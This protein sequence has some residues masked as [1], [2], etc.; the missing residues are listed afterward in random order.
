LHLA[1]DE[2]HQ[3]VACELTIPES[4]DPTGVPDLLDQ[5]DTPFDTFIADGAY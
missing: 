4:G 3:I 2:N 1:V 5:I